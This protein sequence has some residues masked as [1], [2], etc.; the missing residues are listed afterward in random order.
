[1]STKVA[2]VV[3]RYGLEVSGGAELHCR[4]VV[5]R[6]A[7]R[8]DV[9]VLTTCAQD[10]VTWENAYPPGQDQVNGVVVH[11]FPTERGRDARFRARSQWLYANAHTLEDE[12]DWLRAQGP[13]AP[14]LLQFIAEHRAGYDVFCFFTYIYY[15]TALGLRLVADRAVLV[16]T[17]HDEPPLHFS[18]YK[19]LFHSPRAILYNTVEEKRLVEGMFGVGHISNQVAGVGVAVPEAPDPE[20][21][22]RAHS[23][24]VPYV[25]YVGRVSTT[26]YC[27]ELLDCFRRYKASHPGPLALVLVGK[28]EVPIPERPDIVAVGFVPDQTKYDAI[29][30]AELFVLPSRFESLSIAFLESLAV[31][32]PVLCHAASEVLRGHCERSNAA[33]YY[34]SYPEFEASLE[35]LLSSGRLRQLL[36]RRGQEYVKRN[37][38]WDSVIAKYERAFEQVVEETW[39]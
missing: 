36:R 12:L 22:R 18:I 4:Q 27:H 19:A 23:V 16:P 26:K 11:R 29:A 14:G 35:L 17:A 1:M 5:E 28:V 32:T 8:F 39:F 2:F 33:L 37:Y 30:G 3:Q 10:Y 13:L 15:P 24:D 6:L 25:V 9:E 38:T 31:G 7:L 21:F 20:R 34:E